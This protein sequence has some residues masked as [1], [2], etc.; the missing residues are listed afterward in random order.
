MAGWERTLLVP[1]RIIR[2][3]EHCRYNGYQGTTDRRPVDPDVDARR[4]N[5]RLLD[6][7]RLARIGASR[8]PTL[9]QETIHPWVSP[10]LR[11]ARPTVT[12]CDPLARVTC[13]CLRCRGDARACAR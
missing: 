4:G 8:G 11:E 6:F 12:P 5:K 1:S 9:L 13:F 2:A 3:G 7:Q 10:S